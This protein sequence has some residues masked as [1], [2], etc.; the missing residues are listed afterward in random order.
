M[1]VIRQ[2][3]V[4]ARKDHKCDYCEQ[5]I[6]KGQK[7]DYQFCVDGEAYS[8]KSHLDCNEL[9]CALEMFDDGYDDGLTQNDFKTYVCEKWRDMN[10]HYPDI[11][12]AQ[13]IEDV[14][15]EVLK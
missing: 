5:K 13:V 12:F 6:Q 4:T 2:Q 1:E 9:A 7:Y 8:W 15:R 11:P 10:G 14:K 3:I